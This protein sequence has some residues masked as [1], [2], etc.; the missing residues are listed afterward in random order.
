MI[1]SSTLNPA[2]TPAVDLKHTRPLPLSNAASLEFGKSN[3]RPSLPNS[4]PE[5]ND[6]QQLLNEHV[7][8]VVEQQIGNIT[9]EETAPTKLHPPHKLLALTTKA[10]LSLELIDLDDT[11]NPSSPKLH[12]HKPL[13]LGQNST[14][15]A[16]ELH[17]YKPL[18]LTE[19][20]SS[21]DIQLLTEHSS[22]L[23]LDPTKQFANILQELLNK[24]SQ[25]NPLYW[26][27]N[28]PSAAATQVASAN[29]TPTPDL[30]W[31][32]SLWF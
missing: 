21:T 32:E 14:N 26:I 24:T 27:E 6:Q 12:Q 11:I 20:S 15:S 3:H 29:N 17:Y 8:Q 23:L 13:A 31:Q 28:K 19:K 9:A 2:T 4:N 1:S 25:E 7:N 30:A 18:A 16:S 22:A 5:S 10:E